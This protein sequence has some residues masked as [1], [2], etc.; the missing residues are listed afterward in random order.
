MENNGFSCNL[1]IPF[2]LFSFFPMY[3]Q[4]RKALLGHKDFSRVP[5]HILIKR[6]GT[7]DGGKL[8][9]PTIMQLINLINTFIQ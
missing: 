3:N 9:I 7:L 1:T 6:A 5:L 8:K 4:G 2:D